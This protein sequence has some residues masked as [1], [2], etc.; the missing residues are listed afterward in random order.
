MTRLGP[1]E[2]S[3]EES[4]LLGELAARDATTPEAIVR[5]AVQRLLDPE[6]LFRAQ[7]QEGLDAAASGDLHA[8]EDVLA[9][10]DAIL[11]GK[12]A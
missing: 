6:V 5:A 3:D 12:P 10:I 7:V 8:H 11:S 4:R 2:F 9:D 1:I